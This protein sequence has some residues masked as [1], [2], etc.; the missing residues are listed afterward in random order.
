MHWAAVILAV[1]IA[2]LVEFW[3]LCRLAPLSA[4]AVDGLDPLEIDLT[5]QPHEAPAQHADPA[6]DHEKHHDQ[7]RGR[8]IPPPEPLAETVPPS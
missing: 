6:D 1:Y 8:A 2:G 7:D 5:E 4:D 3:R